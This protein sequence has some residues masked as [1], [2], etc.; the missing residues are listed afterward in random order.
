MIYGSNHICQS[1][2]ICLVDLSPGQLAK[3]EGVPTTAQPLSQTR[4]WKYFCLQLQSPLEICSGRQSVVRCALKSLNLQFLFEFLF[5][6]PASKLL[7]AFFSYANKQ[8]N[9][10]QKLNLD[11]E[12][13]FTLTKQSSKKLEHECC[14]RKNA[15]KWN[16]FQFH[17]PVAESQES[18]KKDGREKKKKS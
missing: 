10:Y 4:E 12:R 18:G 5:L 11:E 17:S 9:L 15:Q 2:H 7:V 13:Q 1:N 14:K 8:N 16:N 3:K 6:F